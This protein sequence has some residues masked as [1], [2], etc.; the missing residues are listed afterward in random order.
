[1]LGVSLP[2]SPD[3]GR[4]DVAIVG[5]GVVGAAIAQSLSFFDLK[6]VLIDAASDIGVGTSKANSAILHTGFDAEPGSL[7]AKL[8]QRGH[9]LLTGY[10]RETGIPLKRTGALVVAWSESDSSALDGVRAAAVANGY[11]NSKARSVESTYRMEPNLG[12]GVMGALEIPDESIVCPFTT[13]LALATEAALNGVTLLLDSPLTR[14]DRVENSDWRLVCGGREI[15]ASWVINAA[16]MY[17]DD[18][19][20]LLDQASFKVAPRRGQ[21]I[22]YDRYA[23]TLISHIILGVP[24]ERSKGVLVTPTVFGYL[25][26]GPTSEDLEDKQATE[27]TSQGIAFLQE[28]GTAIVPA[29]RD[30]EV[31]STYAG[32][33]AVSSAGNYDIG[34]DAGTRYGRAIGIRS[35]GLSAS[36]AIAEYLLDELADAGLE[37]KPL[38]G[39]QTTDMSFLGE[40]GLRPHCDPDAITAD[41]DAG[42]VVCFCE[43]VTMAE[44]KATMASTIPPV[45]LEGVRRRTRATGG[46]CQGFYCLPTITAWFGERT[47][48]GHPAKVDGHPL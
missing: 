43:L 8:V 25:L 20:R 38:S 30:M 47:S 40:T 42:Q 39:H 28:R 18:V 3:S 29:L 5:A 32:L 35:T 33:R 1:M 7:E 36:M 22:V 31:T 44:L 16:G 12:P 17:S 10:A 41:P 23:R 37:L 24:G 11:H 9:A 46:R 4:F 21:F 45:S 2:S 13:P 34:V 19:A 48:T 6:V 26:L 15:R 14:S 27:T